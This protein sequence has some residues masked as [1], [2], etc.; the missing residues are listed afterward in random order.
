MASYTKRPVAAPYRD[1]MKMNILKTEMHLS[2]MTQCNQLC[3]FVLPNISCD[4]IGEG[5]KYTERDY[6]KTGFSTLV[7]CAIC[8]KLIVV[9]ID[10]KNVK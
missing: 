8:V 4:V 6:I 9:A 1:L 5:S 3:R 10:M 7:I 2:L